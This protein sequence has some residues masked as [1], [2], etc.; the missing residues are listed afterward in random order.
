M[1]EQDAD[2]YVIGVDVGGTKVLGVALDPAQPHEPLAVELVPTPRGA[3]RLEAVL[4]SVVAALR[5]RLPARR[6]AAVGIGVAGLVDHRGVLRV[7]PNLEAGEAFDVAS[8][9]GAALDVPVVADND[10][11]C[12]LAAELAAGAARGRDEVVYA[13]LGTGIGGALASGGRV[14]RGANGF[15]GEP[16]HMT[17]VRDGWPCACGRQGCWE[18]YASGTGLARLGREAASAGPAVALLD[19]AGGSPG[20]VRGEHVMAAAAGGD[21]LS[22]AVLTDFARWV[23]IGLANLVSL[24]DPQLVLLGG[25]MVEAGEVLMGPVR[26]AFAELVLGSDERGGPPA[27]VAAF[28]ARAA[29][30]GAALLAAA[31]PAGPAG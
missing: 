18:A 24:L 5:R 12:A 6:L 21:P 22:C 4:V 29:A 31:H 15:A 11:N 19:Q 27:E 7:A 1:G 20:L 9:L 23:A 30:T 17:I 26:S 14:V 16:G 25:S 28:G 2:R 3:E 8:R 13:A 10:A